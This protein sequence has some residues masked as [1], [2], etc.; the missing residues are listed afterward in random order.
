MLYVF[1]Q[2]PP[3]AVPNHVGAH[4]YRFLPEFF[5]Y[6]G[7]RYPRI[8]RDDPQNPEPVVIYLVIY[9]VIPVISVREGNQ[10]ETADAIDFLT[11][12]LIADLLNGISE[13]YFLKFSNFS[14]I[15]LCFLFVC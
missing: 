4:G 15:K 11:C 7:D 1:G 6:P 9:L 10:E 13:A 14:T 5:D 8:A 2:V 12:L 3:E